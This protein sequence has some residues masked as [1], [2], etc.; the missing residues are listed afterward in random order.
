MVN[1]FYFPGGQ[2]GCLL[3]HGFSGTP[4]EMLPL[5]DYLAGQGLNID[6]F[7]HLPQFVALSILSSSAFL[8]D[9]SGNRNISQLTISLKNMYKSSTP[10]HS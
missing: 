5:G 9:R 10:P 8:N 7:Y 6:I 1:P 4:A 3:I 2:I